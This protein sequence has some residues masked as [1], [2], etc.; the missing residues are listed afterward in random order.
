MCLSARI[1]LCFSFLLSPP[2][3]VFTFLPLI[4]CL[5]DAAFVFGTCTCLTGIAVLVDELPI[6]GK[7]ESPRFDVFLDQNL[8]T[9]L[10]PPYERLG[11]P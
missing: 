9:Y 7:L 5:G 2:L 6:C 1:L 4:P 3:H 11:R 10:I 8:T